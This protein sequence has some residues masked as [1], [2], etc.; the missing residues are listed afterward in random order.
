MTAPKAL[1]YKFECGLYSS[2]PVLI[3][4]YYWNLHIVFLN[5]MV[6][7]LNLNVVMGL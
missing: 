5:V 1:Y 7:Y 4:L 3:H 2:V 6:V